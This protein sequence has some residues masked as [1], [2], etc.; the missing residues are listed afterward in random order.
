MIYL[1]VFLSGLAGLV[2]EV[3]WMKQLGLLFGNTSH[4]AASTLAAFFAGLAVGSWFCGKRAGRMKNPLRAYAWLEVGIALTA[5][6]YFV[7]LAIFYRIYPLLYQRAPDDVV[8]AFLHRIHYIE[9]LRPFRWHVEYVSPHRAY[10]RDRRCEASAFLHA[11]RGVN[12]GW[13]KHTTDGA[14]EVA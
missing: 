6:L 13:V 12:E 3:L 9:D 2:Y 10:I 14:S 5:L 4:A 8:T 7:I 11:E 1:L